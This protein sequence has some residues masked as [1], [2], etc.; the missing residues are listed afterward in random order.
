M[1]EETYFSLKK[2][3]K[4]VI[5]Q[6][7]LSHIQILPIKMKEIENDQMIYTLYQTVLHIVALLWGNFR[8]V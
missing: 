7:I 6:I 8:C 4:S 2:K 3:H 5:S 1:T